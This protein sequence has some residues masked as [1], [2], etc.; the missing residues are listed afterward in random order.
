MPFPDAGD[1]PF[2]TT[3]TL[4]GGGGGGGS[5]ITA[6]AD[7]VVLYDD[8]N[9][10]FFLRRYVKDDTGG[11]VTKVDTELDGTTGYAVS[12]EANV[13]Q[14]PIQAAG[15]PNVVVTYTQVTADTTT[16]IAAGALAV[17]Y[18]VHADTVTVEGAP[19]P[20]GVGITHEI[21]GMTTDALAFVT[22]GG[23]ADLLII[24]ERAA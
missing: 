18:Y 16:N 14:P 8:G 17:Q 5:G 7:Q 10:Q 3:T 22:S 23:S 2:A 21:P 24:E 6:E 11:S 20:A 13:T 19:V 12:A 4:G 1:P 9:D 15:G